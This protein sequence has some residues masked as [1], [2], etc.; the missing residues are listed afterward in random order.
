MSLRFTKAVQLMHRPQLITAQAAEVYA[1]RIVEL[2][3]RA[4]RRVSRFEALGRKLGIVREKPAAWDDDGDDDRGPPPKAVAYAPLW[5]GEPDKQLDWGWSVKDGIAMLEVAGPLVERGGFVGECWEFMHGYDTIA[6]AIAE[7]DADPSVKAMLIRFDTPGGVVASGIYDLATSL[8]ARGA[9]A[10]PIWAHCEMACS[11]G[12]WIASQCDR[13]IAPAAGLV[14]SIGVV[15]V[16]E[17]Y[18]AALKQHGIEITSVE[19]PEGGFKTDGAWWKA[20][21]P[22]GQAALQSDINELGAAFLATVHAGRGA[23]VT[24]EKAKGFGAQV[25]PA[26]HSDPARDALALGLID[27]VM[28]EREAFEALKAEVSA[29]TTISIPASAGTAAARAATPKPAAVAGPTMEMDMKR[30]AKLA[31]IAGVKAS[32]KTSDEKL[33]EIQKILDEEDETE[34]EG[35]GDEP[36]E[37]DKPE[38]EGE[39]DEPA[40]DDKP[41]GEGEEDKPDA[42]AGRKPAVAKVDPAVAQAVLA[43]PEA[44]GREALAQRLAFKPGMT[45]VEAKADLAAAPRASRLADRVTDPNLSESGGKDTRTDARKIADEA[46]ALAG[47]RARK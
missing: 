32:A 25:F 18:A 41:E 36:A 13:V 30:A 22:E 24:P 37:D 1:R 27:G 43:L 3:P 15:I 44:K 20:M 38:G 7:A 2:D 42:R 17:N 12:Y 21:S 31:A 6:A 19:F 5:M 33:D 40:E 45:V 35:E 34:A 9:G 47:I 26:V 46:L 16:H 11:A 10:K 29:T 4:F 23:L 39:G 14:G 28:S 8:Q